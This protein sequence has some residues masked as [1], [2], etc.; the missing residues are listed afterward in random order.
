[1]LSTL[2]VFGA[3]L[4]YIEPVADPLNIWVVEKACKLC[5]MFADI[6]EKAEKAV[7]IPQKK[8]EPKIVERRYRVLYFGATW[9]GPCQPVKAN[10][11]WLRKSGWTI[12]EG[13]DN[14]I[15]VIDADLRP[16][17]VSKYSVASY[18]TIIAI[19][20]DRE[21]VRQVPSHASHVADLYQSYHHYGSTE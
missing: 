6:K 3:S 20:G 4:A 19:V 21:L 15:Q 13:V 18:P 1:M 7:P 2:I 11:P 14:H 8:A 5:W 10:F 16:D 9:C 17:L 12:G